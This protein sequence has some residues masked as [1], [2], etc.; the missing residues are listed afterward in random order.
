MFLRLQASGRLLLLLAAIAIAVAQSDVID[1]DDKNFDSNTANG[2][3]MVAFI[4]PWCGYCKRLEPEYNSLAQQMS[5][6]SIANI[7]KVDATKS[8][9]LAARFGVK[10]FPTIKILRRGQGLMYKYEGQRTAQ[11]MMETLSEIDRLVM[12]EGDPIPTGPSDYAR[13]L[14]QFEDSFDWASDDLQHLIK[15]RK[16]ALLICVAVGFVLGVLM[17]CFCSR[18]CCRRS[19]STRTKAKNA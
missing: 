6:K 16:N 12:S 7:A 15:Y 17:T 3:W 8:R 18:C 9:E 5:G 13:L 10:G 4:A 19:A 11:A 14:K 2:D 1:L